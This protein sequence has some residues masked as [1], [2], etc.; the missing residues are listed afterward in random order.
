M[1]KH[2]YDIVYL[3]AWLL[4]I[5]T[6]PLPTHITS[7]FCL[8]L[9]I[10]WLFDLNYKEKWERLKKATWILPFSLFFA[11]HIAGVAYSD[12]SKDGFFEV[13]KKLAFLFIPIIAASGKV[14]SKSDFNFLKKGFII[15][16]GILVIS[17]LCIPAISM[18]NDE[19]AQLLNF[20]SI[21]YQHFHQLNPAA[22]AWWEYF[23]YI[24]I[25]SW[26]EMHPAYFSM[27]LIF[28]VII[29][30]Q[31][32]FDKMKVSITSI[33]IIVLFTVFI[34]LLS[35]RMAII[36]YLLIL[37][38]LPIFNAIIRRNYKIAIVPAF[39]IVL[40]FVV[41]WINPVSRFRIIQ[42]PVTTSYDTNPSN[43]IWNS[44]SFRVL[45]W[46]ASIDEL[47]QSWMAGVGP[48]DTQ[49]ALHAQ[50][51][52]YGKKVADLNYNAHNQYLQTMLELGVPGIILLLICIYSPLFKN[53]PLSA[54][55]IAFILLFGLM[56]FTESML[57][58]QKG[59]IFF[60][61]FQSL[62]NRSNLA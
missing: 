50:Y 18:F 38:G 55:H 7:F 37:I 62:Y 42:E 27:Y 31:E 24:Q 60:T 41:I 26:I 29:L 39:S 16:C 40:L 19:P 51:F 34:S 59:I 44:V 30:L 5:I 48:G 13:E 25:G 33:S 43:T 11:L 9:I 57:S 15:A 12:N 52:K 22:S 45:E 58:A 17:S 14:P 20:D 61:L 1:S 2:H 46:K 6:L 4:C 35:S 47:K 32:M 21:T 23:S 36:S 28:C 10:V 56:C 54:E 8:V 53:V 3:S 49:D